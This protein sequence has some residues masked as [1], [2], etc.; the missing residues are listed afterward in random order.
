M[1]AMHAIWRDKG[2]FNITEERLMD[3]QSQIRK[4]QWLTNLELEEIQR[5]IEDEPHGHVPNDSES[6]D[7]QWFLSFVEKGGD[8]FLKEVRVVVD[9]IGSWHEIFEFGFRINR[10][11]FIRYLQR[12]SE[13]QQDRF[14]RNNEDQFYKQI[15][16]SE[17]GEE[18]VIPDVQEA[19]TFG[20]DIWGQ[21]VEHNKDPTWLSE[22]KK[23]MNEKNKQT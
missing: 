5:R 13:F 23:D 19:K 17:E 20:T 18:I 1:N 8:I 7:D 11:G 21:E 2:M 15:D 12:V 4:K 3:Q 22:I 6:E 10:F 16:Q 9:N 14:F